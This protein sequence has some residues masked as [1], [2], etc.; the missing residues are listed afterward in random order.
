LPPLTHRWEYSLWP[1]GTLKEIA[2]TC[3]LYT[4]FSR[5]DFLRNPDLYKGP[6]GTCE[7]RHVCGGQRG[8]AYGLTGDYL[9]SDPACVLVSGSE[10]VQ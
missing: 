3:E 9:E 1:D 10:E 5:S 7:Y 8:R 2:P 4:G 6:C